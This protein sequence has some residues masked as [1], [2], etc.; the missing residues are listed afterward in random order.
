MQDLESNAAPVAITQ[1]T[2]RDE[3]NPTIEYPWVVFQ[4]KATGDPAAISQLAAKNLITGQTTSV[5]T[6]TQDELDPDIQGGRVVWQDWRDVGPGEIYFRDLDSGDPAR[7]ITTNSWGQYHPVIFDNIIVWQD[8]RAGQ[9]DLWGYDLYRNAEIQLTSTPENETRPFM[10][11]EWLVAEEDS[12]GA[13]VQNIRLVNIPSAKVVPLTR[14]LTF[15]SRPSLSGGLIV[16]QD[17]SNGSSQIMSAEMPSVQ[18]V[19]DNRNVVA[20]TPSMVNYQHDAYSLLN[21]WKQQGVQEIK[22]Y[23]SLVPQIVEETVQ[24][25]NGVPTGPNF[26][27]TAGTFLWVKFP[28]AQVLDLGVNPDGPMN[29]AVG[30]N[31]LNYTHFPSDYSAYQLLQQVGLGNVKA[32]RMLDAAAG[33]WV[34]A[35]VKNGGII[36]QDFRIPQVAVVLLD[37]TNAVSQFKPE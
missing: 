25:N 27:L 10:D 31:I 13:T 14:S 29:L 34:V 32:V 12:L 15:K 28:Q 5:S 35:E 22:R 36:G 8:N 7:R 6:S 33:N 26:P 18:A 37:V 23:V 11:G 19:F 1:T 9:V 30:I 3:L 17:D 20:V 21:L 2:G 24:F 16:W 4:S